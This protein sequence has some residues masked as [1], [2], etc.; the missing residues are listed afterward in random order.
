MDLQLDERERTDR[1]GWI[2]RKKKGGGERNLKKFLPPA[3]TV[4]FKDNLQ[5][6][7]VK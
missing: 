1:D 4:W 7:R 6:K 2:E 5:V 3:T